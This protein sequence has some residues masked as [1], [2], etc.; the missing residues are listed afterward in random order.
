MSEPNL[1]IFNA[2]ETMIVDDVLEKLSDMNATGS[3][4]KLALILVIKK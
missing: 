1:S 3:E 2:Q 4:W